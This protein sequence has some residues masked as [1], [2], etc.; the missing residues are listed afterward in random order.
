MQRKLQLA[1]QSLKRI[2]K[3][4]EVAY[5]EKDVEVARLEKMTNENQ[6]NFRMNQ[7][8]TVVAQAV[9]SIGDYKN[10]LGKAIEK[11]EQTMKEAKDDVTIPQS[12]FTIANEV[13]ANAKKALE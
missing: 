3:D 2:I 9:Q 7:Q 5:K 12:E 13:I 6:D 1:H 4:V 10:M 11:L 8:R